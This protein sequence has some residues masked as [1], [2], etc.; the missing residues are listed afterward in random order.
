MHCENSNCA[1]RNLDLYKF[2]HNSI[3]HLEYTEV[4]SEHHVECI[5]KTGALFLGFSI[6]SGCWVLAGYFERL[7]YLI[8]L[9]FVYHTLSL[10]FSG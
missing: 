8:I 6:L 5:K 3:S 2:K 4:K 9:R 1:N 10:L 7:H